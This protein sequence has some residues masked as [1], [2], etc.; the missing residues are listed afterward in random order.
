L[1]LAGDA[2]HPMLPYLAQG[3][4]MAI[5]D[6]AVLSKRLVGI[7]PAGSELEGALQQY[8]QQRWQRCAQVQSRAM[9]N[10]TIFHMPAS[11]AWARNLAIR[12][13]GE[14]LLDVPWLYKG[15]NP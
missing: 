15:I 2:A 8:A 11:T 7:S 4:G 6:A 10:G 9:R 3:A 5:E 12:V 1:A 13:L 14:S